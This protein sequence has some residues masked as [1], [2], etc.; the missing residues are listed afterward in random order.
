[1]INFGRTHSNKYKKERSKGTKIQKHKINKNNQ[2]KA[3][4]IIYVKKRNQ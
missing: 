1:M 2:I 3:M 4:K